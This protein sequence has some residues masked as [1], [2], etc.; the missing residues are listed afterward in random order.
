MGQTATPLSVMSADQAAFLNRA[1]SA[2][3][4][5]TTIIFP[6]Q[7][8]HQSSSPFNIGGRE[9][10]GNMLEGWVFRTEDESKSG[11]SMKQRPISWMQ[12]RKM[13][14]GKGHIEVKAI[15]TENGVRG[16]LTMSES[17]I[18][19]GEKPKFEFFPLAD[20]ATKGNYG[21]KEA[22][23]VRVLAKADYSA[24]VL[25]ETEEIN[26]KTGKTIYD[27][28]NDGTLLILDIQKVP[29]LM[30]LNAE[31]PVMKGR[32]TQIMKELPA[33]YKLKSK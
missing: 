11:A 1:E 22:Y 4:P 6:P 12:L 29:E 15:Q 13:F 25:E 31:D 32:L 5:G 10:Y 14:F 26:E 2:L 28:R 9:V 27:Y 20:D 18:I 21:L 8:V 19:S 3:V 16:N 24:A 17:N 30:Q 7:M 23:I 33:A